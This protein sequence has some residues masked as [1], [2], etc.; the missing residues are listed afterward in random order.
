MEF[1]K[2]WLQLFKEYPLDYINA[3]LDLNISFWYIGASSIDPVAQRGF[4]G[5]NIFY[6]DYYPIVRESISPLLLRYYEVFASY[7]IVAHMPFLALF[8]SIS[9]PIW[10]LLFCTTVLIRQKKSDYVSCLLPYVFLWLTHIAGPVSIFRYVFP[11]YI[12]YPF[13]VFLMILHPEKECR[14]EKQKVH[15]A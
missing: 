6:R 7:R 9:L 10:L 13:I 12:A 1:V 2:L 15:M 4:I 11:I 5:S 3:F 8:F 14:N